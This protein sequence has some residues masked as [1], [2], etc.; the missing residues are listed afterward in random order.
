MFSVIATKA[1]PK[2]VPRFYTLKLLLNRLKYS[3]SA[4]LIDGINFFMAALKS[5]SLTT[6]CSALNP[7]STPSPSSPTL[8]FL[9][10]PPPWIVLRTALNHAFEQIAYKSAPVMSCLRPSAIRRS[11]SPLA[12]WNRCVMAAST[13]SLSSAEL[14]GPTYSSLSNRPGRRRAGSIR[15]GRLV[16]ARMK[17]CWL[18][19]VLEEFWRLLELIDRNF[20]IRDWSRFES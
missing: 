14:L 17:I 13:L 19:S 10:F 6:T 3:M 18:G 11:V 7:S 9:P 4:G 15:S 12:R 20:S 1:T 2:P 8:P 5:P 16:A